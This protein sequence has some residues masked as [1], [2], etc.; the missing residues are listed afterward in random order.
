MPLVDV[1]NCES[2]GR[3]KGERHIATTTRPDMDELEDMMFDTVN[4][5][6]TDGC[7]VE[8]DG[9]CEHGHLSWFRIMGLI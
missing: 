1:E 3:A 8:Q 5:Y 4:C 9:M 2:C 7:D 6:A